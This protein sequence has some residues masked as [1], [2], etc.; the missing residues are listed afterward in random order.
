MASNTRSR[1]KTAT[2]TITSTE[3]TAA[4]KSDDVPIDLLKRA[5]KNRQ[6]A[7]MLKKAKLIAHPYAKELVVSQF[8]M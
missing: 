8:C 5:E 6:K 4:N 2:A 7:L 3:T 1:R